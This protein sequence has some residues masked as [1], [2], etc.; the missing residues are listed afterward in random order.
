MRRFVACALTAATGASES[1]AQCTITASSISPKLTGRTLNP[2]TSFGRIG[3][4]VADGDVDMND[5]GGFQRCYTGAG[6]TLP[7]SPMCP[8]LDRDG[9]NDVDEVDFNAF[10]ACSTRTGVLIAPNQI[11]PGCIL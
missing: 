5:F 3:G 11:P 4:S 10:N 7:A 1:L 8:Q 9:D 2:A 6:G